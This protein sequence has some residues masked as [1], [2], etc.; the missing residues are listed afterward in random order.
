MLPQTNTVLPGSFV[1]DSAWNDRKGTETCVQILYKAAT[2]PIPLSQLVKLFKPPFLQK[3]IGKKYL[4][5]RINAKKIIYE[6]SSAVL[7]NKEKQQRL[8]SCLFCV[9]SLHF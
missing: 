9:G 3:Y 7:K 2:N 8:I 5:S 6:V 1:L 4:P